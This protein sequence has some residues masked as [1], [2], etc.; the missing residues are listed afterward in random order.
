MTWVKIC[1]I[2]RLEDALTA[3]RS[4]AN[5]LGFNFC[6]SSRRYLSPEDALKII[7]KLPGHITKAGIFVNE[8][9][10]HVQEIKEECGLDLLQ[11][12]G[13]EHPEYCQNFNMPFLKVFRIADEADLG[14]LHRF[15]EVGSFASNH[16]LPRILLDTRVD[17]ALGGTG[18]VFDWSLAVKAKEM[19]RAACARMDILGRW[20]VVTCLKRSF[21]RCASW[22]TPGSAC[23]RTR[24]FGSAFIISWCTMS[25]APHR[26]ILRNG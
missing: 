9:D 8:V 17:G 5:A 15:L 10:V 1:G 7:A 3:V 11:F 26:S 6:R 18:E 25:A 19:L 4:G 21:Q 13:D 22:K 12:H 2:T 16:G 23:V 20:A 14:L 24:S